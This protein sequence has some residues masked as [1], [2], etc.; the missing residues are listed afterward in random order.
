[1]LVKRSNFPLPIPVF[2]STLTIQDNVPQPFKYFDEGWEDSDDTQQN[3]SEN[4]VHNYCDLFPPTG[5]IVGQIIT[6]LQADLVENLS[7][8][9]AEKYLQYYKCLIDFI[10]YLNWCNAPLY[11]DRLHRL[12]ECFKIHFVESVLPN[13]SL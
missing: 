5:L 9:D 11:Y 8:L 12:R 7:V 4:H 3:T 13:S 1:M 6:R 2:L 10:G